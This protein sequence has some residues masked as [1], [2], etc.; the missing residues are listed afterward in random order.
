MPEADP[1]SGGHPPLAENPTPSA[2]FQKMNKYKSITF[3]K[4]EWGNLKIALAANAPCST[5]RCCKELGKYRTGQ[6]WKTPWG[7]LIK[8][9][10]VK[11]Y[12]K[13][14]NIPTW[15]FFDKAMKISASYGKTYGGEKW[16]FVSFK[17]T[18]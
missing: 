6:V 15:K 13:P 17:L 2:N 14:E 11:R 9:V 10:K 5:V 8:I 12:Y 1:S 18:K 7:D 16:D 4:K 3:P